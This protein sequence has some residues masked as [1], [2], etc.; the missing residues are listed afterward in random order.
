MHSERG[1]YQMKFHILCA[2]FLNFLVS[3]TTIIP[4]Q[5]SHVS[6]NRSYDLSEEMPKMPHRAQLLQELLTTKETPEIL[7]ITRSAA[8]VL[9]VKD[10]I[11]VNVCIKRLEKHITALEQFNRK[12]KILKL[13]PLT[14]NN[15]YAIIDGLIDFT[16]DLLRIC[17]KKMINEESLDPLFVA[18]RLFVTEYKDIDSETFL[19]EMGY[20][21]FT[22]YKNIFVA[23]VEMKS[24]V[25]NA[26][27]NWQV[28]KEMIEL[29][30]RVSALP[31]KKLLDTLDKCLIQFTAIMHD[32]AMEEDAGLYAWLA[33]YWWVPPII[34][35]GVVTNFASFFLRTGK[36]PS[37]DTNLHK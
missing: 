18:W 36:S 3:S 25:P 20:L 17:V 32:Y 27:V 15:R 35:T 16:H 28:L 24:S 29:Y 5:R 1:G 7:R 26:S 21:L 13:L 14:N 4:A 33:K 31:I 34:L 9:K 22:I 12:N 19:H 2:V 10:E 30:D 11:P 6:R 37:I 8:A 23:Y